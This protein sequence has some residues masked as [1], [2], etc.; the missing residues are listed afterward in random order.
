M[1][2][3]ALFGNVLKEYPAFHTNVGEGIILEVGRNTSDPQEYLRKFQWLAIY[4]TKH[5][6]VYCI[7]SLPGK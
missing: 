6:F 7:P 5:V 3:F 2:C 1:L 4:G